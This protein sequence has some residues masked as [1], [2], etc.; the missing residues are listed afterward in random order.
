MDD[1]APGAAVQVSLQGFRREKFAGAFQ[2]QIHAQ[3][4]PG[5]IRG[6]RMRGEPQL[7]AGYRD[8][9][10]ALRPD[11][12]APPS[13]HAVE[14]QQVRCRCGAPLDFVE[15]NDLETIARARIIRLT[16]RCPQGG[17]Q[18]QTPDTTHAVDADS[19]RRTP[20]F[21]E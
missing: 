17:A 5:D 10:L 16:L 11:I 6:Q 3:V 9:G 1:D 18:R 19:H 14:R 4:T 12:G 7:V 8:G 2:H 15:V 13:L 20:Q 21:D